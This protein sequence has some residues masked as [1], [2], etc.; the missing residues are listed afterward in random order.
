[1]LS[2]VENGDEVTEEEDRDGDGALVS[3]SKPLRLNTNNS[4]GRQKR[5]F[6]L[7]PLTKIKRQP[8]E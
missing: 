7:S 2:S 5:V 1:M 4:K 6:T 8:M 3:V